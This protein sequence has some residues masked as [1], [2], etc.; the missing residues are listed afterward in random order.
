MRKSTPPKQDSNYFSCNYYESEMINLN[1]ENCVSSL[2]K[3]FFD[4]LAKNISQEQGCKRIE[5]ILNAS[6]ING[7]EKKFS[8]SIVNGRSEFL[9]MSVFPDQSD[10]NNAIATNFDNDRNSELPGYKK[11]CQKWVME[12]R[13]WFIEIDAN[14]FD[15]TVIN[16]TPQEL[17]AMLLH[18]LSHVAFSDKASEKFYK[19]Y[20]HNM[21]QLK[22]QEKGAVRF[23][24]SIFYIVP[25]VIACGCHNWNIGVRG[26]YEEYVCDRVF[27]LKDYQQHLMSAINKII[28]AYGNSIVL[29]ERNTD[30]KIEASIDWCNLNI[31]DL[32]NR[33]DAIKRDIINRASGTRSHYAKNMYLKMAQKLGIG[34]KDKYTGKLIAMESIFDGFEDGSIEAYGFLQKYDLIDMPGNYS[35]IES[36]LANCFTEEA[37]ESIFSKRKPSLP[38]NYDI[39]A[40]SIEVDRIKTHQDRMYVLDLIYNRIEQINEFKESIETNRSLMD[41]YN[42]KITR[43]TEQLDAARV[44]VLNKRHLDNSDYKVFVKCPEGYE[45]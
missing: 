27:G 6:N 1:I 18:E 4:I 28:A 26:Q 7:L 40:I 44:R 24:Q 43:M 41:R 34:V 10:F 30:K 29:D 31:K 19:A 13:Y 32:V 42:P 36:T 20:K 17:T 45:G 8:V 38:N 16:F 35:A 15:R 12:I 9:G 21:M 39:D 33:R 11:F 14:V 25:G 3:V 22:M 23:A 2:E 37:R 5:S